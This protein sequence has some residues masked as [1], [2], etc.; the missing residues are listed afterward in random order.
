MDTR[1]A[2]AV[3]L[4]LAIA[5]FVLGISGQRVFLA[6]GIAF[7]AVWLSRQRRVR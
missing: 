1:R 4:A 3:F 6:I 5:L 2:N 7:F